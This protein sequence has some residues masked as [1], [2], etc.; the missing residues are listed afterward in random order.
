MFFNSL[1][2]SIVERN[3]LCRL[4]HIDHPNQITRKTK[5]IRYKKRLEKLLFAAEIKYYSNK[6]DACQNKSKALW[7]L[8]NEITQRKKGSKT[9]LSKIRLENGRLIEN[10]KNIADALNDYFV[11]VGP[12]LAEKL[13]QSERSFESYLGNSPIESFVINPT[14]SDEVYK[15][16]N[17]FS[18]SNCED[19]NKISPKFYK[20]GA[21]AL[22]I[23]LPRLINRCFSEGYFPSCLKLAKV[24]PIFKEGNKE[25]CSNWRPISITSCTAKLI[26]K[27][28]KKRLLS[29][30]SKHDILTDGQFG[31]RSQHST[32]HAILNISDNILSNFDN[33][34]HTVSI[35]LDLSKGFDCVDHNILL[36]KLKHYGIRGIALKFFES[37]LTNRVQQTLV[38]GVLSDFLVVVCGVPQGSVLGPLLFLLYT[39]DLAHASNFL[40]NLFADDTCLSLSNE[41]LH[42]LEILCNREIALVNEWFI[43]NKLT[44]NYKKASNFILSKYNSESDTENSSNFQIKMGNIL[45][46]NVK[47]VKYLGVMLDENITWFDQIDYLSKKLSRSAGIFSKLRYYV[48]TNVLIKVYHALF[49]SHLQYAILCWGSSATTY[50]N[51]LQ[52][53]QNR[54]IRNMMKAPRF[55][56][57]DNYFLNL[58]ILK[59]Q[60][61]YNLEVSKFMHGHFNG[62]LPRRF[63]DFFR[64]VNASHNYNTRAARNRNYTTISCRSARGQR[65]IRFCGPKI[66]NDIPLSQRNLRKLHFKKEC[67][68]RILSN[69]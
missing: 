38:N 52:L 44:T 7:K 64:E 54:A 43:A 35:F 50:I 31:Y 55:Y 46:K 9:I 24:T 12:N 58:R 10:S 60:D 40:V 30:L 28:V 36:K 2:R 68:S 37:Y 66:W 42:Q 17:S 51:K 62:S 57:L 19:P 56:R 11:H 20:L 41:N 45:L 53:L 59:V 4:S 69:Y 32:T 63:D 49:N 39:N 29:Y 34:K 25:V 67:K 33:K 5:Y 26:E 14:C 61:L 21:D 8:I 48:N 65:S 1:K 47:S 18:S 13:P 23:I 27:L 3:I 6:I 16:I 15:G 22:S